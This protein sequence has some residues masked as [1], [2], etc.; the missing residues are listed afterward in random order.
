MDLLKPLPRVFCLGF[1]VP[2]KLYFWILQFEFHA[3]FTCHKIYFWFLKTILK[4]AVFSSC[5][6]KSWWWARFAPQTVVCWPQF[7][8][9]ECSSPVARFHPCDDKLNVSWCRNTVWN[10][11]S[12]A[13]VSALMEEFF[14]ASSS[15]FFVPLLTTLFSPSQPFFFYYFT[16]LLCIFK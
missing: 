2:I 1:C 12:H 15:H 13:Q 7:K 3:V 14:K 10:R 11:G 9:L 16:F 6:Y 8:S 4:M 5:I